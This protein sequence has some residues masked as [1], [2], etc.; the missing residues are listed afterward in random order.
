MDQ[1]NT[2]SNFTLPVRDPPYCIITK[3]FLGNLTLN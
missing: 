1:M 2:W 3:N